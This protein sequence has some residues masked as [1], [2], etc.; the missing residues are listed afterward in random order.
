MDWIIDLHELLKNKS[1]NL[2]QR[3]VCFN[4][5][6][7][8]IIFIVRNVLINMANTQL[9]VIVPDNCSNNGSKVVV[10]VFRFTKN[11]EKKVEYNL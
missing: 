10:Y 9:F 4:K 6:I 2:E 11:K 7:N 1:L 3:E 5:V 8:L